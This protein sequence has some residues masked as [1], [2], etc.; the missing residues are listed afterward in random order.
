M[1][2]AVLGMGRMGRE[3]AGRLLEGAHD[4]VVWNRSPNKADDV[5][6]KGAREASTPAEAVRGADAVVTS[7]AADDAVLEIV[8]HGGANGAPLV[9]AIGPETVLAE[10]STVSPETSERVSKAADSR[11]LASPILGA[12]AAVAS[13]QASYLVA[14]PRTHFDRLEPVYSS[15]SDKV[16][17]LGDDVKSPLE[18]KLLANYLLLSGIAVLGEVVPLA[19]AVGLPENVLRNF[20]DSSP[21]VAPALRNRLDALVSGEHD[22]WF[23]TTLGAK[24]V[25]LA[26]EMANRHGLELPIAKVVE[27]R[28]EEAADAGFADADLTAVSELVRRRAG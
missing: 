18:L 15:L 21:I 3:I 8:E 9:S 22:A 28:Y 17:Y 12:P 25:R 11:S 14:G 16:Q 26:V 19:Q 24:D 2:I 7:L 23:T 6:R 10:M 4:V 1:Q 20:L 27:G 13:G 5:V